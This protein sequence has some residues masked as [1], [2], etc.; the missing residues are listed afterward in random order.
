MKN[1]TEVTREFLLEFVSTRASG[2]G[3]VVIRDLIS[4]AGKVDL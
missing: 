3:S 1:I 4:A 2:A